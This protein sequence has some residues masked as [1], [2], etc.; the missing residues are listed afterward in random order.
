MRY[1]HE[2]LFTEGPRAWEISGHLKGILIQIFLELA[3]EFD[4]SFARHLSESTFLVNHRQEINKYPTGECGIQ[5][6]HPRQLN[7]AN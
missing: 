6:P 4:V 3:M 7:L 1:T 5:P 2:W